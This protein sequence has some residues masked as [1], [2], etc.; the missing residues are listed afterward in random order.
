MPLGMLKRNLKVKCVV[1]KEEF[2][3]KNITRGELY[4]VIAYEWKASI[5]KVKKPQK[6]EP[7]KKEFTDLYFYVLNDQQKLTRISSF[8]C[9]I[10]VLDDEEKE[11]NKPSKS[12]S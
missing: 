10:L 5:Q 4:P 7:E 12:H 6:G 8:N 2:W 11:D 3:P 1:D 9:M